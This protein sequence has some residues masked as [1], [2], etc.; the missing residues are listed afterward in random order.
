MS[1]HKPA[2]LPLLSAWRAAIGGK[3]C[4][5]ISRFSVV[6]PQRGFAADAMASTSVHATPKLKLGQ[7]AAMGAAFQRGVTSALVLVQGRRKK[8]YAIHK[9]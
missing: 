2:S 5:I 7:M 8:S 6:L 1:V 4:L 3:I 9:C